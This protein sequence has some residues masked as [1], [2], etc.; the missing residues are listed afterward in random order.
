MSYYTAKHVKQKLT[1][2]NG[3]MTNPWSQW[4]ILTQ[5]ID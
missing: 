2:V 3:E 5:L 1:E 4:E